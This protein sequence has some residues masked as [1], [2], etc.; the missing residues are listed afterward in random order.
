VA[1]SRAAGSRRALPVTLPR[2]ATG[3]RPSRWSEPVT[4]CAR[5]PTRRAI[6]LTVA[7]TANG[8]A[9][10]HIDEPR[11][12]MTERRA[13]IECDVPVLGGA[14]GYTAAIRAAEL[15]AR[16]IRMEQQHELGGT[17]LA[18]SWRVSSPKHA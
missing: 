11:Q 5:T 3:T 12:R 9:V 8:R 10:D 1:V 7:L 6:T 2:S 16:T 17:R 4:W 14:A 15:A 18:I 13:T